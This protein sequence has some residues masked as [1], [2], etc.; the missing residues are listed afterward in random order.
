MNQINYTWIEN[1][2]ETGILGGSSHVSFALFIIRSIFIF[3]EKSKGK[4]CHQKQGKNHQAKI[5]HSHSVKIR[6]LKIIVK[7]SRISKTFS[8]FARP[9]FL[10][11]QLQNKSKYVIK[12]K[13]CIWD[14]I[15]LMITT[16][17]RYTHNEYI[18]KENG[19]NRVCD[20]SS[21]DDGCNDRIQ[22]TN[23]LV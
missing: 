16:N 5:L 3:D 13:H 4:I 21:M 2:R 10:H 12:G 23:T 11:T 22:K 1:P 19:R 9:L 15:P 8:F 18:C 17:V 7:M 6:S 14:T 20:K